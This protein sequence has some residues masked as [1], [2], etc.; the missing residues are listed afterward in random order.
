MSHDTLGGYGSHVL[1]GLMNA[2]AALEFERESNGVGEVS[3][4]GGCELLI[5]GHGHTIAPTRERS[6]NGVSKK[7]PRAVLPRAGQ[8][9]LPWNG[10]GVGGV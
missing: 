10:M 5:V 6:K 3:R 1:V 9:R 7:K 8:R 2:L 4:I